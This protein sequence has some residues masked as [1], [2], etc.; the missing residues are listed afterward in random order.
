LPPTREAKAP[1]RA[2]SAEG[3]PDF[4]QPDGRAGLSGEQLAVLA[5]RSGD[6]AETSAWG[7]APSGANPTVLDPPG[8]RSNSALEANAAVFDAPLGTPLVA[9]VLEDAGRGGLDISS[10]RALGIPLTIG[11]VAGRE[12]DRDLALAV[13]SAGHE[14]LAQLP[15]DGARLWATP[16]RLTLDMPHEDA[17][18]ETK[19]LMAQ[20]SVAVAAS[21]HR[22][23]NANRDPQFMAAVI[24]SLS[25][26]GYGFLEDRPGA[27]SSLSRIARDAQVP[28]AETSRFVPAGSSAA[29]AY[30]VIEVAAREAEAQ[31][32]AIVRGPASAAMLEAVLRWALERSSSSARIAPLS[33]VLRARTR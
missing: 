22:G 6:E 28:F 29:Q 1:V 33:A 30:D 27:S 24:G 12:G 18:S 2:P 21:N 19:R 26:N 32:S 10:L 4:R 31:G 13:R 9:V 25:Q 7:R 5:P 23:V 3:L 17:A 15:M 11:V 14:I 8:F 20:L 16:V